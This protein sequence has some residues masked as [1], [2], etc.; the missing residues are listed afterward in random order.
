MLAEL[1]WRGVTA[2]HLGPAT[3]RPHGVLIAAGFLAGARLMQRYTRPRGVPDE[4]LWGVL[5]WALAGGLA[6]MR[7]AWVLGHWRELDGI[8]EAL[9]IWRGG[10]SL[11][12]GLIAAVATGGIV[13]R[14][15]GLQVLPLLDMASPGLAVGIAI[16]RVSDLIVADHLGK[17]TSLP[18]GFRYVGADH[19][20]QGAPPIGAVVHPVAL[21]DLILTTVL[22]VVLLRFARS[23]R[24]TG[25]TAALFAL[26]YAGGRF[27]TDFLR[28]DPVRLAGLTGSQLTALVVIAGV[29]TALLLR[30]GR[31]GAGGPSAGAPDLLSPD[32][33]GPDAST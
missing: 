15:E 12:G 2:I 24:A 27:L 4:A 1:S 14:R 6:G 5:G 17:P 18:W 7:A 28:T 20:L 3:L 9:A 32:A 10:M 26:W 11:F 13:A 16:G 29:G 31:A 19:P 30:A 8:G 33:L 22:L 25:S 21:Y 23:P